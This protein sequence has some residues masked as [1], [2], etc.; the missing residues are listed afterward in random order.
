MSRNRIEDF[1]PYQDALR[2]FDQVVEDEETIESRVDLA[3]RIVARLTRAIQTLR[4]NG[5]SS[6]A[7]G[8]NP[9]PPPATPNGNCVHES[10][11]TYGTITN[12]DTISDEE[13]DQLLRIE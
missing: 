10:P 1:G 7:A 4:A 6:A 13:I 12:Q 11:S 2:L 3:D 5:V 8:Q 9:R